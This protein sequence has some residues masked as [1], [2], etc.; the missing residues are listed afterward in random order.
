MMA[1][2][3]TAIEFHELEEHVE[4]EAACA[5]DL[6]MCNMTGCC[7]PSPANFVDAGGIGLESASGI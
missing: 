5:A 7:C 3:R 2:G 6:P 1:V 4:Q